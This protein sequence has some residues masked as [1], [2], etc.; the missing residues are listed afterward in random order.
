MDTVAVRLATVAREQAC[1]AVVIGLPR[2]LSGRDTATTTM[3]RRVAEALERQG[4]RVELWDE[5]LSS[6][7]AERVLIGA[8]RRRSRRRV[9]RDRVAAVI[10]LQGWLDARKRR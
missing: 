7:E 6:A 4:V 10:I 1:D 8:G 3:A 9:E 2:A 5:R